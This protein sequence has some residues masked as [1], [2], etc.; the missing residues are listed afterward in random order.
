V[1]NPI[2]NPDGDGAYT[3]SWNAAY[4]ASTYVLQEDDNAAFSSPAQP[5]SGSSTSWSAG[6]KAPGTY[7]Y[8]VKAS[9]SW[10]DSSWSNVQSVRVA[11]TP[12][13]VYVQNDTIGTLCYE[14]YGSGHGQKCYSFWGTSF[15]GSFASGTYGWHATAW[16]G[17]S[18]GTMT[19][20]A[21]NY[22][23]RF[24]CEILQGDPAPGEDGSGIPY[25]EGTAV[26]RVE[27]AV[28][29]DWVR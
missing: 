26:L 21:G 3:V 1:L 17:S 27:V 11:P 8:R 4:L 16:C 12:S 15:Y 24:W 10:G 18:S 22:T 19:Y 25:G 5:Y 7:Y 13:N 2:S 6:G 29:S 28:P 23:H 14:V 20:P 9:N